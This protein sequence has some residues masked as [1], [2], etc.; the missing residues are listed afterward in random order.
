MI[1]AGSAPV[2]QAMEV[3]DA[4]ADIKKVVDFK[5]PDGLQKMKESLQEMSLVLPMNT[6][7]LMKITAAA[8]QAGI[9]E[10]DLLK[11]T[12]AAAKMGVAFDMSAEEAGEMMAKWRSGMNLTQDE[13]IAL[14]DATNALSNN[15]A[16]LGSQIGETLKRYGALGK[17]AGLT[18]KQTAALAATVIGSGAEAEVAATGINA[19]M[20]ALVKGGSMSKG[21]KAAFQDLGLDPSALQKEVKTDA[22]KAILKVLERIKKVRP[23]EQMRTLTDMFGEEGARA[24]GP[25]LANTELLSKNFELVANKANYAGSMEAEFQARSATTSN[26]FV[27]AGNAVNY[28]AGMIGE[29]LLPAIKSNIIEFVQFG[30][31][32]GNWIKENATLVSVITKTVIGIGALVLAFHAA[33]AVFLYSYSAALSV[34]KGL[35]LIRS[36]VFKF[37]AFL[38]QLSA[39]VKGVGLAIKGFF[40]SPVGTAIIIAGALIGV[41]ILIYK[42]WDTIKAKLGELWAK[43]EEA[44]PG[45]AETLTSFYN[46][47]LQPTIEGIKTAFNGLIS[48]I[49]GVFSGNWSQAWTGITETFSGI[50][51]GISHLAKAP[52]NGVI[53][54]VNSAIRSLN[55]VSFELPTAIPGIGGQKFGINLPEIPMLASGGI[56]TSPTLSMIGEGS[57]PEAV[58]P[59]SRLSSMMSPS[60]SAGPVTVN[61]SINVEGGASSAEGIRTAGAEAAETLKRQLERILANERRLAY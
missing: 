6:V 24:M 28:M 36:G 13:A 52:I 5:E 20:R 58:L 32:I 56:A 22:P 1:R 50:F 46:A 30:K 60:G 19:F 59:L 26:A 3:E 7:E 55:S 14:A 2:K 17:V 47:T 38:P 16:A 8:G 35:F 15:N 33:R 37:M 43:F 41:G 10:K 23:E 27:L 61:L 31:T 18:E 12:E 29:S 11:F 40:L 4:M 49:T 25:M 54:L 53:S 21:Q 57:E 45:I 44:F 34:V 48:F 51:G 39:G 9:A 42:N